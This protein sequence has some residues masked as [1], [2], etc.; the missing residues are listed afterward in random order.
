MENNKENT[1]GTLLT[2]WLIWSRSTQIALS[3]LSVFTMPNMPFYACHFWWLQGSR[4][5]LG[6]VLLR[7]LHRDNAAISSWAILTWEKVKS[8][9]CWSCER[10]GAVIL[11]KDVERW[12]DLER[13]AEELSLQGFCQDKSLPVTNRGFLMKHSTSLSHQREPTHEP[14]PSCLLCN[15]VEWSHGL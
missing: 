2:L 5:R 3:P 12:C 6:K 13:D 9:S 1:I 15:G 11:N 14:L 8:A 4:G 10:R 7:S